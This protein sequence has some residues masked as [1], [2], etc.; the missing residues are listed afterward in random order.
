MSK[1]KLTIL[2][3][4][5]QLPLGLMEAVRQ[6]VAAHSLSVYL[7]NRQNLRLTDIPEHSLEQ[8]RQELAKAGARIQEPGLF[9]L[10]TVCLGKPDCRRGL[11]DTEAV[12][13]EIMRR[14]V[15]CFPAWS[16]LKI[17]VSGCCR[18]CSG[19]KLADIGVIGTREGFEVFAGGKGGAAPI[20]GR[21]IARGVALGE[22]V[23]IIEALVAFLQ[24]Q[25][26]PGQ[27]IAELMEDPE[28]P[29]SP[30]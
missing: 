2:L 6:L 12:S 18:C 24:H 10:P 28:F 30:C 11:V 19:A 4:A 9:P 8:V 22:V 26:S 5:G 21:R 14:F 29:L 23:R 15:G 16:R 3:P 1:A 17:A 25:R 27:R 20:V 13:T 7:T